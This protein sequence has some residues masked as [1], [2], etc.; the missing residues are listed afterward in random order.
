M[1][2]KQ[3]MRTSG[4]WPRCLVGGLLAIGVWPASAQGT[5]TTI[6]I[7][8]QQAPGTPTGAVFDSFTTPVLNNA[9]QVAYRAVLQTGLGGVIS[10]NDQGIWRDSSLV[11]REGSQ[12]PGTPTGAVFNSFN[13]PVLNDAG[14]VAYEGFLRA[15][16]GGVDITNDAG[17]WHD[18]SILVRQGSQAPGTP[19]GAVFS[20]FAFPALNNAGQTA[21]YADL[22]TGSGGVDE[23]N[24]EGIWR[25]NTLVARAG[26]QAGGVPTGAVFSG[27]GLSALLN[28][29]GQTVFDGFLQTG[30]GGV[31]ETNDEGI[32]RDNTLIAREGS[33][34]P[35]TPTGVVF[36]NA[37][38]PPA[39]NNAG[40]TA[41]WGIL[42][43]G[44]GGVDFSNDR[45]IW[46]DNTLVARTGSQAPDTPT[47]VVFSQFDIAPV[48]NDTG[49][50]VFEGFLK[51]GS[52]GVDS[53][54]NAGIW[55]D[56]TLVARE[57]SQAPDTP[58]GAV[59]DRFGGNHIL[60]NAGQTVYWAQ[61]RTGLSGV[62]DTNDSGI[63]INGPNGD[64]LLIAREGDTLAGRAIGILSFIPGSNGSDG[65]PRSFNNASQVAYHAT[66]T[67][68]DQGVFLFTPDLR[69]I[70]PD[71]GHWDDTGADSNWTIGQAPGEVHNVSID[72]DTDLTVTAP[73]AFTLV[74]SLTVGG[75][76]GQ[77]TMRF[78]LDPSDEASVSSN[79]IGVLERLSLDGK[80]EIALASGFTPDYGDMFDLFIYG[81]RDGVFD[82]VN[83]AILSPELALGQF[84]E[85]DGF[86]R[87]TLLATAPGDANGDLIVTIDDFG[88]LAGNFNQPGTWETGDFD[89]DGM[90]TINDF[91]LLAANFNG[92]FNDLAAAAESFGITI[93]EPGTATLIGLMLVAFVSHRQH[94]T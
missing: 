59:F 19:T 38:G 44:S 86:H 93:P 42:R 4:M 8:G 66:F 16:F 57:G 64:T 72:P 9:G 47:G 20:S 74:K 62:D 41:F 18:N 67:N 12:A 55:R 17:I 23:T 85:H 60:N 37:F 27:F 1:S 13:T 28:D 33:Q 26:E 63:W 50:V 70:S 14:Q 76:T 34:A 39:L 91:G 83:G 15:G 53:T 21:Y 84:Y 56:N 45:G 6:A 36:S 25:D 10:D 73:T 54:N 5:T 11:A 65:K 89:G 31:D 61:L 29:A 75:G 51:T 46:R 92:D 7:T 2:I 40:Q 71:S 49:H 77:A 78:E 87:I 80:L 81:E 32:W 30:S 69:W 58:T 82:R 43:T 35:G 22:Q 88:V 3:K 52:G 68:G 94:T 24:N 79:P 90:T 48:L